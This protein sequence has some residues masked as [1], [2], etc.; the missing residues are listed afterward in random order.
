[1]K[2]FHWLTLTSPL[3]W[4]KFQLTKLIHLQFQRKSS[5][6]GNCAMQT[7]LNT[8][9]NLH[10]D[11]YKS[12]YYLRFLTLSWQ[13]SL[14]YRNRSTD[15]L[16][17]SMNWFLYDKD[18]HHERVKSLYYFFSIVNLNVKM[19]LMNLY[20][21]FYGGIGIPQLRAISFCIN[22]IYWFFIAQQQIYEW[23]TY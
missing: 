23:F 15:L 10:R 16:C 17:K 8:E 21:G 14:S 7:S 1:M 12:N 4:H 22:Q 5:L 13:R 11:F 6:K 3:N 18:F 2:R 19:N 9:V 20:F